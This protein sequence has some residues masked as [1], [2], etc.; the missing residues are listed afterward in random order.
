MLSCSFSASLIR[1]APERSSPSISACAA[2]SAL[3]W[4]SRTRLSRWGDG[5]QFSNEHDVRAI[6]HPGQER[7]TRAPTAAEFVAR[8]QHGADSAAEVALSILQGGEHLL[9]RQII[10]DHQNVDVAHR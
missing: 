1:A 9:E 5:I 7:M 2:G 10:G 3:S 4:P 8:I 6:E